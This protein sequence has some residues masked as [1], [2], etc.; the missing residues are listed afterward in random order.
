MRTAAADH[1][2]VGSPPAAQLRDYVAQVAP[3]VRAVWGASHS[4]AAR[5]A[6]QRALNEGGWAAPGWPVQYGGRG[7]GARD[8][9]ACSL[10]L[11][12][13]DVPQ[14]GGVLGLN[15][16]APALMA[17]GTSQQQASLPKILSTEELWCQGFSEPEAG[18]D[19]ASLRTQAV[20]DGDEFVVNGQKIWTSEG[21]QATHC[22]LLARTDPAAPKHQGISAF[23][24]DMSSPGIQRREI[25]QIDGE[26]G[27]AEVFFTD[28]RVPRASLLGPLNGGWPVTMAT[29]AHERAGVIGLAAELEYKVSKQLLAALA[30]LPASAGGARSAILRERVARCYGSAR[31]AG[32]LGMQALDEQERE[33][34]EGAHASLIKL[35]WAD[36]VQQ[37]AET[38][39]ELEADGGSYGDAAANY[40][41][42]RGA[43]IAGGTT[44]IL[45]NL[46][47]ERVL[48]LAREPRP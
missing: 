44:E 33:P 28:V 45:K 47:G 29:L 41:F 42:S 12:L 9:V 11:A 20:P 32:L 5:L 17:F 19:L 22:L 23:T 34:A 31:V 6:W 40:L 8:G 37:V 14:L 48:G 36:T 7:L 13:A 24:V 18:S 16:V 3:Q 27:F 1:L 38:L 39:W 21:M 35:I 10:Q 4:L 30:R 25:R 15:N 46:A 26:A 43:T 2:A